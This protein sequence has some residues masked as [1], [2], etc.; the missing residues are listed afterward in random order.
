MKRE[1][2]L[3]AKRLKE[4][5][6]KITQVEAAKALKLSQAVL[7][8]IE[9]GIREPTAVEL[10]RFSELYNKQ[11]TYFF[12]AEVK[13][14][15]N[16]KYPKLK[17]S[18]REKEI[19]SATLKLLTAMFSPVKIYLFGSRAKSGGVSN[20]DFDIAVDSPL[21][22]AGLRLKIKEEIESISGL[23]SVDI[24]YLSNVDDGFKE[25]ITK[26]GVVVYEKRRGFLFN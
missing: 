7:S 14:I 18:H 26:T 1:R 4:A 11:V 2:I 13:P 22:S 17:L 6:G 12:E 10:K 9:S 24:V 23:Y 25:I 8:K 21:P 19:L 15:S 20:A 3:L 16:F 5:R